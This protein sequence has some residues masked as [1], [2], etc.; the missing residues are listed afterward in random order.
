M[1]E[2][3]RRDASE[4]MD[5]PVCLPTFFHFCKKPTKKND[6]NKSNLGLVLSLNYLP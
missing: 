5:H 4:G 2:E 6:N 1:L 3:A